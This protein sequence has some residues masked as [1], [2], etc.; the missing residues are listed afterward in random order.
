M[1]LQEGRNINFMNP[2]SVYTLITRIKCYLGWVGLSAASEV[3]LNENMCL[4]F[5]MAGV[6]HYIPLVSHGTQTPSLFFVV[7]K[8]ST[9]KGRA[10]G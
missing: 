8:C 6:A 2:P 4:N 9:I 3:V 10:G 5:G 7:T 1:S